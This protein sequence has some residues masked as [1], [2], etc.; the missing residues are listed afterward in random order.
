MK[1]ERIDASTTTQSSI[2]GLES[3]VILEYTD[4]LILGNVLLLVLA[5]VG[6][7]FFFAKII[8]Q[9]WRNKQQKNK[10]DVIDLKKKKE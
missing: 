8:Y 9:C 6:S 10:L 4:Y 2:F 1:F 5:F 7:C 3:F